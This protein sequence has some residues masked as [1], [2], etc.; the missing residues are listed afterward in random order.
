MKESLLP[1]VLLYYKCAGQRNVDH[2]KLIVTDDIPARCRSQ[3]QIL[4]ADYY[5]Y[6]ILLAAVTLETERAKWPN[7]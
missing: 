3:G 4:E 2:P 6:I 7:L 5:I 1:Y